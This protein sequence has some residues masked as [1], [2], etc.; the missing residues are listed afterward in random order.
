MVGWGE[1]AEGRKEVEMMV[2]KGGGRVW[3][4]MMNEVSENFDGRMK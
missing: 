2:E 1:Y 3:Q 4:D